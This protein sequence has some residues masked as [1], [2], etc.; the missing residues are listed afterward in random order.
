[1]DFWDESAMPWNILCLYPDA[2]QG[3]PSS[4]EC[5]ENMNWLLPYDFDPTSAAAVSCLTA[6][7]ILSARAPVASGENNRVRG[8]GCK[9]DGGP[10][11]ISV[12]LVDSAD[13]LTNAAGGGD[14]PR[15]LFG[16]IFQK[17]QAKAS[18]RR[19][20]RS[21]YAQ[22]AEYGPTETKSDLEECF[23]LQLCSTTGG[24]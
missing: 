11:W 23:A 20:R 22:V 17:K 14:A 9:N 5:T 2:R 19:S 12:E 6:T 13:D 18:R 16:K 8:N 1:M 10:L 15:T 7:D 4:G 21:R 24:D 3:I